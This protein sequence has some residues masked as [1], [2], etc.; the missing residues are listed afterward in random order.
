VGSWKRIV[1]GKRTRI[2]TFP[3]DAA[4]ELAALC[5][6]S[7][8]SRYV[9]RTEADRLLIDLFSPSAGLWGEW[10]YLWDLETERR[11]GLT[12]P[13]VMMT[14]QTECPRPIPSATLTYLVVRDDSSWRKKRL[15]RYLVDV[16]S[17]GVHGA[18]SPPGNGA[19]PRRFVQRVR[20]RVGR[21][22]RQAIGQVRQLR[23]RL[24]G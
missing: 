16:W 1:Q 13:D 24:L 11:C 14:Q 17:R 18:P 8:L 15:A 10:A 21:S 12:I 23:K 7:P 5:G 19:P 4:L 3:Y 2:D 6:Q 9:M 20:S 22:A